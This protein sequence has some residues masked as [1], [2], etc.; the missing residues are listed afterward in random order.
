MK[1]L[2]FIVSTFALLSFTE[3][4][5]SNTVRY[6]AATEVWVNDKAFLLNY[7]R[8]TADNLR[9]SV[10]GLSEEQLQ[11]KPSAEAWSVSQC[12]EHI[13]ATEG[14][15]FGM[16]K[17]LLEQP[18]NPERRK[19]IKYS[20]GEI[21]DMITDRSEKYKAPEI[22]QAAGKY[23]DPET[24]LRDL[25]KQRAE[26]TGFIDSVSLE[27]LRNHV[28]DSPSGASDAYQSFLFIAGHT[29]RHTLQIEEVKASE[30]FPK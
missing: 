24:A 11:F 30:N 17:T 9:K 6:T 8:E 26:I 23:K 27:D 12:L 7:Y 13:V 19:E 10:A 21:L 18:G 1:Q 15:I 4:A 14:M 3:R 25:E 28:S 20:D 29:A 16:I 22:L 5:D 2:I